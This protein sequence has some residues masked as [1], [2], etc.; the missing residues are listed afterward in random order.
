MNDDFSFWK[1]LSLYAQCV[2]GIIMVFLLACGIG[3]LVLLP[4]VK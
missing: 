1:M 2:T 3:Y 4:F